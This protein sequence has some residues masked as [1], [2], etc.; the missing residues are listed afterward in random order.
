MIRMADGPLKALYTL[1]DF[2]YDKVYESK[3]VR[4]EFAK[5]Q[6]VLEEL[7]KH[8]LDNGDEFSRKALAAWYARRGRAPWRAVADFLCGMTDRYARCASIKSCVCPS[9]GPS[10]R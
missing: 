7:W 9:P 1:R 6:R 5:A 10:T 2:L 3:T 8:F 4:T